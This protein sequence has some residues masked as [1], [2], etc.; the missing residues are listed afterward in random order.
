MTPVIRDLLNKG[1][2]VLTSTKHL[3]HHLRTQY[4][5]AELEAGNKTWRSAEILP[6]DAWIAELWRRLVPRDGVERKKGKPAPLLLAPRP[7]APSP[8][9]YFACCS[10]RYSDCGIPHFFS[11]PSRKPV[12][13]QSL[14]TSLM[15]AANLVSS[16][17]T[18]TPQGSGSI[19]GST[20]A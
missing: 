1:G 16:L 3:A 13:C 20:I 4:A 6:L 17:R 19:D 8:Y 2:T 7:F 9:L 18:P 11:R 10:T 12:L 5:L 14:M 15:Y